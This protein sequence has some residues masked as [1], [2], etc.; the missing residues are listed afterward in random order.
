MGF[1]YN[2]IF[3]NQPC[4][5][6]RRGHELRHAVNISLYARRQH[7]CCQQSKFVTLLARIS[8]QDRGSRR[9]ICVFRRRSEATKLPGVILSSGKLTRR[10]KRWNASSKVID[11]AITWLLS[12]VPVLRGIST[13]F[14]K[15]KNKSTNTKT[16]LNRDRQET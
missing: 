11:V 4:I 1:S 5:K 2:V 13:S 8:H 6:T 9:R 16:S 10:A 12:R 7:P 3:T 14:T 15:V